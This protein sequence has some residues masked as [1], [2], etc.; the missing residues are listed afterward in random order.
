MSPADHLR[1]PAGA[2]PERRGV[3]PHRQG[4]QLDQQQEAHAEGI[5]FAGPI[6]TADELGAEFENFLKEQHRDLPPNQ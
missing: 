5:A 2:A 4:H 3:E 1:P 6:P